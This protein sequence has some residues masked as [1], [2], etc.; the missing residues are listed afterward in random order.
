MTYFYTETEDVDVILQGN[1]PSSLSFKKFVVELGSEIKIADNLNFTTG[2]SNTGKHLYAWDGSNSRAVYMEFDA[3]L[4]NRVDSNWVPVNM[5]GRQIESQRITVPQSTILDDDFKLPQFLRVNYQTSYELA[6]LHKGVLI[7]TGEIYTGSQM[8]GQFKH[9]IPELNI[10][11][12]A[13]GGGSSLSYL[14]DLNKKQTFTVSTPTASDSR[15]T[16]FNGSIFVKNVV[17]LNAIRLINPTDNASSLLTLPSNQVIDDIVKSKNGYIAVGNDGSNGVGLYQITLDGG[18][19]IFNKKIC[20]YNN[21]D[22]PV[23][24]QDWVFFSNYNPSSQN[25]NTLYVIDENFEPQTI[26]SFGNENR[27]VLGGFIVDEEV[28]FVYNKVGAGGTFA[29]K[30][31]KIIY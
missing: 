4:G 6:Y 30:I 10:S 22:R 31:G 25:T 11:M 20:P 14:L 26:P 1:F 19:I 8:F 27:K 24:V 18:Q 29:R 21:S 15:F 3:S 7:P 17:T 12:G 23:R 13:Y 2:L 16:E 28:W 5:G 9:Y